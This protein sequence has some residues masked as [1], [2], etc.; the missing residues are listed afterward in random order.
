MWILLQELGFGHFAKEC[1]SAKRV[2]DYEY[3]KEN[4]LLY[5]KEAKG[6]PLSAEQSEWLQDT[7]DDPDEQEL[8]AHYM[9]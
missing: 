8:E 3:H 6:I 2:K 9:Y 4:M 1:K 7:V 5:K